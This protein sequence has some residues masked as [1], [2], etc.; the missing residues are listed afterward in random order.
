MMDKGGMMTRVAVNPKVLEWAAE[1]SESDRG[2][3]TGRFP[4]LDRWLAGAEESTL[5]Q[6][7][8]FSKA[9]ST[10]LGFLFLEAPPVEQLPVPHYRTVSDRSV[11]TPSPGLLDT[12][13]MMQ[14]RQE[15]LRESLIEE[16]RDRVPL[17]QCAKPAQ[18]P[19]VVAERLREHLRLDATWAGEHGDWS[20]AQ[21]A[22]R[23]AM[24][25]RESW[26]SSTGS[27]AITRIGRWT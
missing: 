26:S 3:L 14:R 19:A 4:K 12:I 23:D 13:Y 16:G 21:R 15:W 11:H 17:V 22:L 2:E 27:S 6:L 9:T 20:A 24:D 25:M 8:S 5:H 10:P 1:R 7:E 18:R